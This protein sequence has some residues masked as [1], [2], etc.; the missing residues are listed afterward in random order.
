MVDIGLGNIGSL[1]K[2]IDDPDIKL[3]IETSITTK[4]LKLW[5]MYVFS[6]RSLTIPQKKSLYGDFHKIYDIPNDIKEC[7]ICHDEHWMPYWAR[8]EE[9]AAKEK[10]TPQLPKQQILSIIEKGMLITG[11]YRPSEERNRRYLPYD[12]YCS[13]RDKH[14][15]R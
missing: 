11:K 13:E 8:F 15:V 12:K 5:C 14:L 1:D 4:H 7:E 9:E 3:E 6:D 2:I 10:E